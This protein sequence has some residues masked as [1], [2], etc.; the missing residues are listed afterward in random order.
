MINVVT[1]VGVIQETPV[2]REFESGAKGAFMTLRVVKPFKSMDGT[3]DS[4][5]IKCS[6]WE[7][8]ATSTCE[9]C[10]KGDIV[11]I[12]GRLSTKLEDVSFECEDNIL[13]KKITTLQVIVERVAFISLSKKKEQNNVPYQDVVEN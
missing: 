3:Y 11:G 6:L 2:L 13:H 10:Q 7:G 12:R 9:F 4:E 5:F 1:L 8:I